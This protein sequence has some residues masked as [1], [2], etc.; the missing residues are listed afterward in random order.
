[1]KLAKISNLHT[2]GDDIYFHP[3]IEYNKLSIFKKILNDLFKINFIDKNQ[4]KNGIV[5]TA[6]AEDNEVGYW[7]LAQDN[8]HHYVP[9]E[10]VISRK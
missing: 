5:I 9:F 4:T 2:S 3:Y 8:R 1:M 7:V 6:F 10:N